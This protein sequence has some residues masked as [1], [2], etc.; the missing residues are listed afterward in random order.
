MVRLDISVVCLYQVKPKICRSFCDTRLVI[1]GNW[2]G[3]HASRGGKSARHVCGVTGYVG[4]QTDLRKSALFL[5]VHWP[6][7]ALGF[8]VPELLA[9]AD[10]LFRGRIVMPGRRIGRLVE[11]AGFS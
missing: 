7:V 11:E 5:F 4:I 9:L 1:A 6:G 2:T 8:Y 10:N 3:R